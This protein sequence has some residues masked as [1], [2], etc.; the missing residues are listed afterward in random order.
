M[1]FSSVTCFEL[2]RRMPDP[3]IKDQATWE[4]VMAYLAFPK[5]WGQNE[6]Y[7]FFRWPHGTLTTHREGDLCEPV[8]DN[9]AWD[10]K[11]MG[12]KIL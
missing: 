3:S 6:A 11:S 5:V 10:G 9:V 1:L 4:S 8:T 2:Y 12:E 7:S